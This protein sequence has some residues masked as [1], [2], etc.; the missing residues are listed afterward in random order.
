MFTRTHMYYMTRRRK[1]SDKVGDKKD[2]TKSLYQVGAE[3]AGKRSVL[4]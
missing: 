3:L 4:V 2:E 1:G